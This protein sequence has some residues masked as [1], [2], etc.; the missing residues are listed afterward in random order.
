MVV[1]PTGGS[2]K[3]THRYVLIDDRNAVTFQYSS[4]FI[5]DQCRILRVVQ[6]ITQEHSIKSFITKR[7][8]ATVVRNEINSCTRRRSDIHA[9]D[10]GLENAGE[11]MSYE[12]VATA[13]VENACA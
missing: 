12:S 5:Q 10:W 9:D 8:V 11:M 1:Y 7:E 6:H 13:H 2:I 3:P 4:Y